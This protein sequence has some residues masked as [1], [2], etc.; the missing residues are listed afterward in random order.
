MGSVVNTAVDT[1]E[2]MAAYRRHKH[3]M[4]D[5][6]SDVSRTLETCPGILNFSE[7][8]WSSGKSF[9]SHRV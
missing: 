3:C 4:K 6:T 2:V 7:T 1:K 9:L 8:G 5:L